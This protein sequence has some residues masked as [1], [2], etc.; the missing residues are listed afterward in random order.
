[1]SRGLVVNVAEL[2]R[3]PG[4]QKHVEL[5]AEAPEL[6]VVDAEVP[7]GETIDVDVL[8]ESLSDGIVVSGRLTTRWSAVCRR[9]LAPIGQPL[10]AEVRELYQHH[11][12]SD[13]AFEFRGEQLDLA[14]MVHEAVMLELPLAP[15]CRPDCA[16]LCPVCGADRNEG[17]CGHDQRSTDSRWAALDELRER[18]DRE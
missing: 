2:L 15:L 5:V 11:A 9:C 16:G 18:L 1:M 17:D 10:V 14:P 6:R 7:P 12:T 13:D 3:R 8:M 4:T